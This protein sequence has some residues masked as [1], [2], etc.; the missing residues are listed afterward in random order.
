[1]SSAVDHDQ[2]KRGSHR[3]PV[4]GPA[5]YHVRVQQQ[6]VSVVPSW[7]LRFLFPTHALLLKR[8]IMDVSVVA[9]LVLLVRSQ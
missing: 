7:R 5:L 4:W 9:P 2:F 8:H 6:E 1:M 3:R